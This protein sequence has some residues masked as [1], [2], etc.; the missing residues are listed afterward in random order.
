MRLGDDDLCYEA[1]SYTWGSTEDRAYILCNGHRKAVTPNLEGA[2]RQLRQPVE[3]RFIWVDAL[4]INQDDA[5]E[6]GHQVRLMRSIY[7]RASRVLVWLG[8]DSSGVAEDAFAMC[9]RLSNGLFR[10]HAPASFLTADGITLKGPSG[11]LPPAKSTEW[12]PLAALF[13]CHW[14][15]RLWVVQEIVLASEALII[16]GD[17]RISWQWVASAAARVRNTH[18]QVIQEHQ[19]YGVFNAYL[20]FRMSR[21][22]RHRDV[23]RLSF[24]RTLTLTRQFEVSDPRD[25]IYGLLGLMTTDADPDNGVLFLEPDYG[26]TAAELYAKTACKVLPVDKSLKLLSAVQHGP[27]IPTD[28]PSWVPQWH[29][30]STHMLAPSDPEMSFAASA[31]KEL[32]NFAVDESNALCLQGI[33]LDPVVKTFPILSEDALLPMTVLDVP[34]VQLLLKDS[35]GLETLALTLTAGKDWYGAIVSDLSKHSADLREWLL[36]SSSPDDTRLA[37]MLGPS[38]SCPSTMDRDANRF[39][40][41]A[42]YACHGRTLFVTGTGSIGLGPAAMATG[43]VVCI[44]FGGSIPY[45]LRRTGDHYLFAGE[46]YVRELMQGEALS[47]VDT[48]GYQVMDFKIR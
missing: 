26:M 45:I 12:G 48:E 29:S 43:D 40:E 23:L 14:F 11:E 44:L 13:S 28:V 25:R 46:S 17:S 41:A 24:L 2:L 15:W 7:K 20:L 8:E 1:L 22:T 19:I 34:E 33:T 39:R 35:E 32:S 36:Q 16:W 42:S 3:P 10:G 5:R 21:K 47:G 31:S 18:F 4:S 37:D 6:R 27:S 30:A 9:C 38:P